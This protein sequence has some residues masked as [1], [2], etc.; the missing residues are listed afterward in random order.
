MLDMK[1]C[2][3]TTCPKKAT[4]CRNIASG[5]KPIKRQKYTLFYFHW[6]DGK[7][8]CPGFR[9]EE[10]SPS[11]NKKGI[12]ITNELKQLA[13]SYKAYAAT[14]LGFQKV[15]DIRICELLGLGIQFMDVRDI[16]GFVISAEHN[17]F[18][19]QWPIHLSIEVDGVTFYSYHRDDDFIQ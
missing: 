5:A 6:R 1:M 12:M 17:E 8:Y 18:G 7:V 11:P 10:D 16:D 4:C 15:T 14:A 9:T 2:E 19:G 13:E 3:C